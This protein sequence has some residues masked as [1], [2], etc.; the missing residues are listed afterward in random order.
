M[1]GSSESAGRTKRARSLFM[2][3][4]S[5]VAR[6]V[7][8]AY[9]AQPRRRNSQTKL[10]QRLAAQGLE[11][12]AWK[13]RIVSIGLWKRGPNPLFDDEDSNAA[14]CSDPAFCSDGDRAGRP[15]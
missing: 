10:G 9:F 15:A 6:G 2:D 11:R 14:P 3:K 5:H 12:L 7:S 1:G 8:R 13:R 4:E